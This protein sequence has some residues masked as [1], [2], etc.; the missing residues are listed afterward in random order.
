M[1][2][3]TEN[4]QEK[5]IVPKDNKYNQDEIIEKIIGVGRFYATRLLS[6][7]SVFAYS[8]ILWRYGSW[9]YNLLISI[10]II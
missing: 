8:S 7:D 4:R 10:Y 6:D 1:T 3:S 2:Q 5:V 9:H